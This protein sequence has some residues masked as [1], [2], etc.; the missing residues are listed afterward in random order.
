[1]LN[2][3]IEYHDTLNLVHRA[4]GNEKCM[5]KSKA[6]MVKQENKTQLS[7]EK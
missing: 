6:Y 3:R 7:V 2:Q 5:T 4:M 1:M